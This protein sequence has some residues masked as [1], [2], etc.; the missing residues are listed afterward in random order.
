MAEI[1]S[2]IYIAKDNVSLQKKKVLKYFLCLHENVSCGHSLRGFYLDTP[3]IE[4]CHAFTK[5]C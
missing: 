3:P 2:Y 4:F 1:Y 5:N